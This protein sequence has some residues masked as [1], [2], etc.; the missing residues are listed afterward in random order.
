MSKKNIYQLSRAGI[1]CE[2]ER[3]KEIKFAPLPPKAETNN[4]N[5]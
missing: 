5:K 3:K 4:K 1:V 2:E